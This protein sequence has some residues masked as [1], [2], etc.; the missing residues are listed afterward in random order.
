MIAEGF[1]LRTFENQVIALQG[2]VIWK[3]YDGKLC[4]KSND[5]TTLPTNTNVGSMSNGYNIKRNT[6]RVL[7]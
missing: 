2:L 4:M 3:L 1:I 5:V 6:H 7:Q